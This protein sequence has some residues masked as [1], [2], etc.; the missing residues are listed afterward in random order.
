MKIPARDLPSEENEAPREGENTR[1]R[2]RTKVAVVCLFLHKCIVF[3][4]NLTMPPPLINPTALAGAARSCITPALIS[5][6]APPQSRLFYGRDAIPRIL[7]AAAAYEHSLGPQPSSR[8]RA[9][10][11]DTCGPG[12]IACGSSFG[13]AG[14]RAG[15]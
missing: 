8:P 11:C 2:E 9:M 4:I 1:V 5:S 10:L 3:G 13:S 7:L 14:R 12:R 6:S 15:L